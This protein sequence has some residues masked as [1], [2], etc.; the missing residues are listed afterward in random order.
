MGRRI[1][2]GNTEIEKK[3]VFRAAEH[4]HKLQKGRLS[5]SM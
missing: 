2:S 3:C 4:V 5:A 1:M